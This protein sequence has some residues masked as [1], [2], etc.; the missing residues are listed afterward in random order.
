MPSYFKQ[1]VNRIEQLKLYNCIISR[2]E[3]FSENL[4]LFRK[5][6]MEKNECNEP[7]SIYTVKGLKVRCTILM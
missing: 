2:T 3:L 5:H 7:N 1:S 6:V 4:N